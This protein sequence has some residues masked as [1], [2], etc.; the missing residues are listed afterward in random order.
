[1]SL[2]SFEKTR[3][4]LKTKNFFPADVGF[5]FLLLHGIVNIFQLTSYVTAAIFML[6]SFCWHRT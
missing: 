3:K 4:N 1:M 6:F 5:F 2:A